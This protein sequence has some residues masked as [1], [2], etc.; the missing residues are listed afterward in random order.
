[1][2]HTYKNENRGSQQ[3]RVW[4][5]AVELSVATCRLFR[6]LP[7]ELK[8]VASQPIASTDSVHLKRKEL[9]GDWI[10]PLTVKEGNV[11]CKSRPEHVVV[12]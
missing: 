6:P 3:L 11:P 1:M 8:K 9:T 10:D 2:E 7:F 5:E 4:Q 12:G